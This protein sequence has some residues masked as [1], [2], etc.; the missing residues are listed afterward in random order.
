MGQRKKK[1]R[2]TVKGETSSNIRDETNVYS[3]SFIDNIP[4][5][6]VFKPTMEE[7]KDPMKYLLSIREKIQASGIAVIEPPEEWRE[8]QLNLFGKLVD[9]DSMRIGTKIQPLYRLQNRED[10]STLFFLHLQ[11]FH[12]TV[13]KSEMG[14]S[15]RLDGNIIDFWA[16]YC[17]MKDIGG[18]SKCSGENLKNIAKKLKINIT[19]AGGLKPLR[20][21]YAYYVLPYENY[22]NQPPEENPIERFATPFNKYYLTLRKKVREEK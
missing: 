5:A 9:Y 21:I 17:F 10:L 13:L 14:A 6:P 20:N 4:E 16:F 8:K 2:R 12:R 7:F 3:S 18:Y 11:D 1:K 19:S 22:V 15:P